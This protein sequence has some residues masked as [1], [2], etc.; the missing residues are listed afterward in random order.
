MRPNTP[1]HN[2]NRNELDSAA[3]WTNQNLSDSVDES[4]WRRL[5]RSSMSDAVAAS[6][7]FATGTMHGQR[8]IGRDIVA[9]LK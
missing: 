3:T 6:S 4:G 9:A 7:A 8:V 1:V 5:A 2:Q